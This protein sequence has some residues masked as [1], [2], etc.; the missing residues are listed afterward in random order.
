MTNIPK[1]KKS[2]IISPSGLSEMWIE[3]GIDCPLKCSYC[4][5]SAGGIRYETGTLSWGAY[6]NIL[7]QFKDL[8]GSTIGIPGAGE[9]LVGKNL[10]TTLKILDFTEK[11]GMNLVIFT[12]GFEVSEKTID[13][14]NKKNVSLMLKYNSS[15][16]A[17]QDDLVKMKNYLIAVRDFF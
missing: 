7:N 15:D 6:E 5:N 12:S 4:F 13:A 17:I 2:E 3:T 8:G 11:N 1:I 14:I 10:E 9:P 16:P